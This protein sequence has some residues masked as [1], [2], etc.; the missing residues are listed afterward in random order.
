[1]HITAVVISNHTSIITRDICLQSPSYS[2]KCEPYSRLHQEIKN[3]QYSCFYGR[4][5][6]NWFMSK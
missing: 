1:M 2:K 3:I 5:D 6:V 4:D